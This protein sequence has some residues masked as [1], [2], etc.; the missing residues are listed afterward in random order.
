[1]LTGEPVLDGGDRPVATSKE[2]DKRGGWVAYTQVGVL[3]QVSICSAFFQSAPAGLAYLLWSVGLV[4][5]CDALYLLKLCIAAS[6]ETEMWDCKRLRQGAQ[7]LQYYCK[8][9]AS[10][11]FV[12]LVTCNS[13]ALLGVLA[14]SMIGWKPMQSSCIASPSMH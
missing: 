10:S 13:L 3:P 7:M 11:P 9:T 12:E 8:V 5:E 14:E 6:G 1:M 2:A 4:F